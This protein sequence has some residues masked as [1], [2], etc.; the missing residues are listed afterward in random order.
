M[1]F[2]IKN[3]GNSYINRM[4]L[5][6]YWGFSC[7]LGGDTGDMDLLYNEQGKSQMK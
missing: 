5:F 3:C 4:Q 1:P 6:L 7:R 2:R